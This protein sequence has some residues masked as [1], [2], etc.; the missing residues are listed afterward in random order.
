MTTD[1]LRPR[2]TTISLDMSDFWKGDLGLTLITICLVTQIFLVT[3][4]HE[5]GLRIRFVFD[6]LLAV[7]MVYGMVSVGR[8]RTAKKVVVAVV[9][10]CGVVLLAARIH[11]TIPLQRAGS[12]VATITLGLYFL[13]VLVLMF[14][15][16]PITWSR[17]QGGIAAY[18]LVG[19]TWASAYQVIE[20][21]SPGA[22]QFVTRPESFD[23]LISKMTYYSFSILTTVGSN[24]APISPFARSLTMAESVVGQLFPAILISAIVAMAMRARGET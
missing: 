22:F 5:E 15:G 16:G 3:P 1:A 13:V 17:I 8:N 18:L 21:F 12:I 7:L 4:L 14:R 11:P 23:E 2:R 10:I 24:I 20:Q 6:I 19:M 9:V